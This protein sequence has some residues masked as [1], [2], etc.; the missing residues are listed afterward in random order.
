[1]TPKNLFNGQIIPLKM[2]IKP[3]LKILNIDIP[4]FQPRIAYQIIR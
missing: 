4:S 1:M 3:I 2:E